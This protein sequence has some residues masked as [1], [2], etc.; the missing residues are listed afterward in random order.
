[1]PNLYLVGMMGSG[2]SVTGKRLALFL[3]Y[4]FV[5]LDE[6][7]EK[8]AGKSINEIFEKDGEVFFR[9]QETAVLNEVASGDRVVVATGGGCILRPG[10]LER[11]KATGQVCYLETSLECLWERVKNKKDRPL[12]RGQDPRAKLEAIFSERRALYE[13]AADFQVPTDGQTAEAV[14]KKIMEVLEKQS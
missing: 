11:M 9:E 2:K 14:A 1:M 4:S 12:L 13:K 8:R 7:L 6:K 10:N 5:D 3:N